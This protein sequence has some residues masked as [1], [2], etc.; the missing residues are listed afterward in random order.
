MRLPERGSA[1]SKHRRMRL[2]LSG[3]LVTFANSKVIS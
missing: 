3:G 1:N 2:L